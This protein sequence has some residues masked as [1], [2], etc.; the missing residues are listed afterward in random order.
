MIIISGASNNHYFTLI[1]FI[2]SVFTHINLNIH[3]LIIYNLD[4]CEDKWKQLIIKYE[5]KNII[6]KVF[7]YTKYPSWFNIN[8]NAGE[9]AWK[10]A[11]IYENYLLY[12]EET[13]IWMDAGNIVKNNL[14]CLEMFIKENGLHTGV[15]SGTIKQWTYIKTIE[16]MNPNNVD[17]VNRNGACMGFNFNIKWVKEFIEEFYNCCCDKNCI[18]PDGSSRQN[19]RQDQ[20]VLTILFYK[21]LDKYKFTN[22]VNSKWNELQG[23]TIH[24]DIGGSNNPQ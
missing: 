14:H 6:F 1:Q 24:N 8:I 4:I 9:Y 3:T 19:H 13:I 20:S 23:Y 21:Y 22:Y 18:A 12:P 5:L 16:Y 2:N 17:E 11:I 15:S 10:P 7:D